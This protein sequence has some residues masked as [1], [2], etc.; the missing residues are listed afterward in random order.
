[1]IAHTVLI[2]L[3][4]EEIEEGRLKIIEGAR[5]ILAKLPTV[6][7]L[8]AGT[9]MPNKGPVVDSS[10]HAGLSL[11][12]ASQPDLEAY[13][14]HPDHLRYVEQAIKPYVHRIVVY[15]IEV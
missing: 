5:S 3:K 9:A 14:E 8:L 11:T 10:F 7:S 15:D 12:F 4:E 13:L 2:W 1:M 6:R